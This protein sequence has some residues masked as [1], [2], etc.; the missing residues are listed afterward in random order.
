MADKAQIKK[1]LDDIEAARKN[2]RM[3]MAPSRFQAGNILGAKTEAFEEAVKA[4]GKPTVMPAPDKG[5]D[6]MESQSRL[7]KAIEARKK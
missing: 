1:Q 4:Q 6:V 2:G 3:V 5:D 7:R